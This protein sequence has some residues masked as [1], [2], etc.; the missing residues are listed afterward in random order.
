[1]MTLAKGL[2]NAAVPMSAIAASD[3]VHDGLMVGPE[4]MVELFHGY[5]YSGHPLA[6]AAGLATLDIY[7][8]DGLF[9]RAADMAP[10]W[11]DALH[12]LKGA[13]HVVDIRNIGLAGAV[14]ITPREG[15]PGAR[16]FD[17]FLKCYETGLMTRQTGETIALSPPL[18]IETDQ[19]NQ[20]VDIIGAA[21]KQLD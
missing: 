14:E 11:E 1:M 6:C 9:Q 12:S 16:A 7:I 15:Q 10:Y 4:N 17:L 13:A 18:I 8:R 21:L 2:T 3:A 19:I 20:I 5:T